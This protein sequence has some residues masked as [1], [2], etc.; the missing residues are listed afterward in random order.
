MSELSELGA[1]LLYRFAA[2]GLLPVSWFRR[3]I[4]RN[5]AAKSTRADWIWFTDA[6]IVFQEKCLD[7]LADLLQGRSGARIHQEDRPTMG[8][9]CL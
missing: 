1:M 2:S 6:D 7:T 4:G 9:H 8:A 5:L 3:G